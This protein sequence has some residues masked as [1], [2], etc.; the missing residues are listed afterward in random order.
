MSDSAFERA[1]LHARYNRLK[2]KFAAERV[3]KLIAIAIACCLAIA[4]AVMIVYFA[5]PP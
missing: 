1:R 2:E 3:K 4:A 5:N